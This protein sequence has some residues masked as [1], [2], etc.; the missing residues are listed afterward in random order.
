MIVVHASG[1]RGR[2]EF[3]SCA[4]QCFKMNGI[5]RKKLCKCGHA[6]CW[7]ARVCSFTTTRVSARR[8]VYEKIF[9]A[10]MCPSV[11]KLPV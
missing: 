4:C 10:N 3:R 8:G 7:H 11:P 2:C 6:K 9:V 1:M 5:R